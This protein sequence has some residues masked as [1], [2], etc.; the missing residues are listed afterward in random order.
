MDIK[1][2][3][4]EWGRWSNADDNGTGFK[5]IWDAIERHAPVQD[6]QAELRKASKPLIHDNEGMKVD[7]A[8][9]SL[10]RENPVM[11]KIIQKVYVRKNNLNE[12]A[13]YY[14]TPMEYPE[15]ASMS[16][17]HAD[18]RKVDVRIARL[19]LKTAESMVEK[20]LS[21]LDSIIK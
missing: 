8:V 19:L 4:K 1:N 16:W 17:D 2:R 21:Y 11:A 10:N 15:Q 18:K 5:P 20:E 14:L 7:K 12:V 9:S 13:Q 3:L 6:E